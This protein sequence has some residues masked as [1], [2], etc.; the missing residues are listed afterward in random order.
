MVID[1][2]HART[3]RPASAE[4]ASRRQ[5][6]P[7]HHRRQI[8]KSFGHRD[9][10]DVGAPHLIATIDDQAPQQIRI[11]LMI[12][13]PFAG[14]G[15]LI[16]RLDSHHPHQPF[17]PL[18]VHRPAFPTEYRRHSARSIKRPRQMQL[19]HPPHHRKIVRAYRRRPIV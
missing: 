12:R 13:M 3:R 9:I 19:I 15:F 2:R 11:H 16:G 8:N 4:A 7:V 5:A 14:V 6:E 1:N 10:S 18:A 17:G